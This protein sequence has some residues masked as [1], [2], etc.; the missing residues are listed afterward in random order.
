MNRDTF[1]IPTQFGA[2]LVA[3][4]HGAQDSLVVGR[5]VLVGGAIAANKDQGEQQQKTDKG[6]QSEQRPQAG[7][8]DVVQS[9]DVE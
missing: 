5:A 7:L 1:T 9:P 4:E 3:T 8:I 2:A 6:E